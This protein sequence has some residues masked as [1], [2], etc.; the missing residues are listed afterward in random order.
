MKLESLTNDTDLNAMRDAVALV[1]YVRDSNAT[2]VD[3]MFSLIPPD[4]LTALPTA[5]LGLCVN[6]ANA[7]DTLSPNAGELMLRNCADALTAKAS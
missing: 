3:K 4:E 6:L 5:L 1:L 2:A 7:L